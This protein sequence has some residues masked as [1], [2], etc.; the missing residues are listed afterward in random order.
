[1]VLLARGVWRS[2]RRLPRFLLVRRACQRE[3]HAFE[4]ARQAT[5]DSKGQARQ[6]PFDEFHRAICRLFK[7]QISGGRFHIGF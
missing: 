4:Q 1:M 5:Q 2:Q 6:P 3:T 7:F